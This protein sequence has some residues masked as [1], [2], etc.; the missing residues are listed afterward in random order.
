[1]RS[2]IARAFAAAA[3][4]VAA[5]EPRAASAADAYVVTTLPQFFTG[6][7]GR[8]HALNRW[9]QAIGQTSDTLNPLLWSPTV[10]NGGVGARFVLSSLPGYPTHPS[11]QTTQLGLASAINDR[12][13]IVGYA[14]TNRPPG[15]ANGAISWLYTPQ[16][17]N[18][19]G[20]TLN[21]SGGFTVFALR[22]NGLGT[23]SENLSDINNSGNAVGYG[24]YYV[25]WLF[26]AGPA[27]TG[28]GTW[29]NNRYAS[30]NPGVIND[31]GIYVTYAR[32]PHP[33]LLR[34]NGLPTAAN[35]SFITSSL[36]S[37]SNL[38]Q[39]VD[40]S[41]TGLILVQAPVSNDVYH[42]FIVKG[43]Q[44]TDITPAGTAGSDYGFAVNNS[45][46]VVG[47]GREAWLRTNNQRYSLSQLASDATLHV[48]V[49]INDAGQI[50]ITADAG[51]TTKLLTP[52]ALVTADRATASA[53]T[54]VL[55]PGGF[56]VR[57]SVTNLGT[58]P[59]RG[60]I[61][62]ALDGLA[63]SRVPTRAGITAYA[64]PAGAPYVTVTANDLAG[65]DTAS[66]TVHITGT[67]VPVIAPRA[68]AGPAPR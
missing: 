21:T 32:S 20:G 35:S 22:S 17:L 24:S 60:P 29:R 42:T 7:Y 34:A 45:A 52:A 33:G 36:W 66:R 62:V 30:V 25:P 12:G 47:R 55:T 4:I 8:A 19:P 43:S 39:P 5:N 50:L 10:A 26:T 2:I 67:P 44:V 61:S 16:P 38:A 53:T 40:I 6:Y 49:S 64:G 56:D 51:G 28:T 15:D 41:D 59:L 65:G 54:P 9:G 37:D 63:P 58:S 27:N 48:P 31:N 1:M 3:L 46:M 18:T 68:L 57:L 23:L 14:A 13:Q 11:G